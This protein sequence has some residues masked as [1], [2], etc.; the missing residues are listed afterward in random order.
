MEKKYLYQVLPF[1]KELNREQREQLENYFMSAPVWLMDS[2]KIVEMEKGF[3][4]IRENAPVDTIY[5]IGKGMIKLIDYRIYGIAFDYMRFE[6]IYAM[7]GMEVVM[8]L[9]T[10][11]TTIKTVTPCTVITIPKAQFEKWLKTDIKALKQEA[12][13]IGEYLLQ[14]GRMGRTFLFLQGANRLCMLF[15]QMYEQHGNG[16]NFNIRGTRQELAEQTGLCVK[17]INRAVKKF[18]EDSLISRQGNKIFINEDQY[19]R[20][21]VR[22]SKIIEQ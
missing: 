9:D 10:Y 3:T 20:M 19:L 14:Q 15:I 1:M 22:I 7:G 13:A 12:K 8:D 4:F 16:G 21:K 18:E 11:C 5:I 6:G 2:F 17:T